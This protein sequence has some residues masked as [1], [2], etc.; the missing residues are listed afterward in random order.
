MLSGRLQNQACFRSQ[1][2]AA[3]LLAKERPRGLRS[4]SNL[5]RAARSVLRQQ[6]QSGHRAA[7]RRWL[8]LGFAKPKSQSQSLAL[9]LTLTLTPNRPPPQ[10]RGRWRSRRRCSARARRA[11]RPALRRRWRCRR[12]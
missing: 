3:A 12:C 8:R 4:L 2:R 5:G 6:R 1:A 9:A 10:C 7:G 11:R